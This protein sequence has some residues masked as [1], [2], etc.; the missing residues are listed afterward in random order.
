MYTKPCDTLYKYKDN[1]L[2]ELKNKKL[3]KVVKII[4]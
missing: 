1:K 3:L 4:I 2:L